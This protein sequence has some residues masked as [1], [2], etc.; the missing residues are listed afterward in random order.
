[1]FPSLRPQAGETPLHHLCENKSVSDEMLRTVG[2]FCEDAAK[3]ED[4]VRDC[5]PR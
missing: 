2:G 3:E 4:N 5:V 1:M